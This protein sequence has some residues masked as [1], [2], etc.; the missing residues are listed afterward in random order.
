MSGTRVGRAGR[1]R[2]AAQDGVAHA[3]RATFLWAARRRRLARL[4]AGS[5]L[6]RGTV[7]RFVAGETLPEALDALARLRARGLVTTVDILGE[8]VTTVD[9]ARAAADRYLEVLA[10]LADRGL[11]RNVSVKL[12]QIGL[13]VDPDACRENLLRIV[14]RAA[15]L[16]AFVRV[17]ME[18]H[19]RTDRTLALVREAQ[20]A[21]PNV[22]VVLQAYLRRTAADVAEMNRERIRV[23]LCKGAYDEPAE[24]AFPHKADVD[25]SFRRL[26]E[27]LL[28]EGEHPAIATHDELLISW[29]RGYTERE[30]IDRTR[31]E[32]QMLYGVRRDLQEHL[33]RQGFTVRVYVPFGTEWYPYFMRR[34]AERPAN[35]FFMAQSV[36]REGRRPRSRR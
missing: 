22:G 8:S 33:A 19:L 29:V 20:A 1:T 9:A 32:F 13:D 12:T 5:A 7:R 6:T 23:R 30:G 27:A 15:E 25:D 17:D 26:V 28:R 16:E 36:L 31:F 3:L 35:V 10:A 14:A 18:D 2:V 21:H 11:D 4:A 34:L 24:V